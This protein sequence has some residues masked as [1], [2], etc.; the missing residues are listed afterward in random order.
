M[1]KN[2]KNLFIAEL[3][4]IFSAEHQIVKALPVFVQ[5]A[6]SPRLKLAFS[7]HLK[8]T[9]GQIVRLEKIFKMLKIGKKAKFCK[10]ANGLIDECKE[11][12]KEFKKS[13]VRDAALISK[14]QRIEHYEISAYG[15]IRT[16][17]NLLGFDE[18]ADLLETSEDEEANADKTLTRIAEGGLFTSG[19]NQ[20]ATTLEGFVFR[21]PR[22]TISRFVTKTTPHKRKVTS[23][24]KTKAKVVSVRARAKTVSAKS[25]GKSMSMKSKATRSRTSRAKAKR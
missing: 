24:A 5:A 8:E 19:I 13:P 11:V 7:T 21:Q 18:I 25:R 3:E 14:A 17:A 22:K 23:K 9:K 1:D 6:E 15:T 2:I 16:F 4:D 20:R 12:I 10:G